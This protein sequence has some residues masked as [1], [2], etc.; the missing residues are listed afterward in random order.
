MI[1]LARYGKPVQIEPDTRKRI[2][3]SAEALHG[4]LSREEVVYGWS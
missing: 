3:K 2:L 1:L 4:S